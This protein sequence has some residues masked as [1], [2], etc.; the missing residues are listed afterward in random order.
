MNAAGAIILT[1]FMLVV[2]FGSRRWAVVGMMGGVLFLTQ[3]QQLQIGGLNLFAIRFMEMAGFARVVSRKELSLGRLSKIDWALIIL[4]TY[5][6]VVYC[7]RATEG[8]AY[9]IGNSVDAFLCYFAFRGMIHDMEDLRWFLRSFIVLLGPFA[10]LVLFESVT[11]HNPFRFIGGGMYD[12]MRGGR[13]R[14]V[15]TFRNPDLLGTVGA[16]FLPLYIWLARI[17]EER[18]LALVCIGCCVLIVWACNSG[19]PMGAA[20]A[21]VI[22]SV[23]WLMRTRMYVVRRSMVA[24]VVLAALVMKA[25]VWY[26]LARMSELTGGDGWHRSYLLDMAYQ[27]IDKWWFAGF[28]VI[29]T[30]DWFPYALSTG[31]DITNEFVSFGLNAGLAAIVLFIYLLTTAFSNLG[32]ALALVRYQND[33]EES[34]FLLWGLGVMVAAHIVNWFGITYFDQSYAIW[35]MQL[36][37]VTSITEHIL[38]SNREELSEAV[39]EVEENMEAP[40]VES[41]DEVLHVSLAS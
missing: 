16:S 18:K 4:F 19:G 6:A 1:V 29:E 3:T 36:A 31:A 34:E 27:H 22:G 17:R 13:L 2:L 41:G 25:P 26:L 35:F 23:L 5:T 30:G 7:L 33:G 8:Q 32:K 14:C 20:G 15:G 12:W 40:L 10:A 11:G 24:F 39:P 38:A 37:A 28:P 9:I 21:G